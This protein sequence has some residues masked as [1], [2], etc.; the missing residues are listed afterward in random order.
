MY[1][2]FVFIESLSEVRFEIQFVDAG[3]GSRYI[4]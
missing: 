4:S 2:V 1:T 3:Y